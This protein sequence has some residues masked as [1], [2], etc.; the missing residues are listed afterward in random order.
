MRKH[1]RGITTILTAVLF[2]LLTIYPHRAARLGSPAAQDEAIPLVI[3]E[4]LARVPNDDLE[5]E[6]IEGDANGDGLRDVWADEF[7][8][9]VN[10]AREPLDIG[11]FVV[12]DNRGIDLGFAFP[13]GTII[14]PGEA[15]VLFGGGDLSLSGREF[16]NARALGLVFTAGG[17][18][19]SGLSNSG[20]QVVVVDP[21]GMDVARFEFDGDSPVSQPAAQSF[22]RNPDID[23]AFANHS[24]VMGAGE[25]LFSPGRLA[26]GAA[27]QR[28]IDDVA[29]SGGP[30][31]GG[32]EVTIRGAGFDAEIMSVTFGGA[33]AGRVIRLSSLELLVA[34][35][36]GSM[37]GAVDVAVT[38]Q[39]G[40][41]VA[42][43][44]YTYEP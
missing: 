33:E 3:N 10:A 36:R 44:V 23:G 26:G 1:R 40:R 8:E 20:D 38:D 7:V 35:P 34:V 13:E 15:V 21:L 39:F 16:G 30:I 29:P 5:T 22:N 14:P 11:G 28:R 24:E 18:I 41:I 25:R 6:E 42:E 2:P 43:G 32:N 19:G 17:R 12:F 27:F 4:V 9:L 37:E 31:A